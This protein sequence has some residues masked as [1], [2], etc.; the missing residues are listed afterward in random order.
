MVTC[1]ETGKTLVKGRDDVIKHI[2]A[3]WGVHPK[4][5]YKLNNPEAQKRIQ[6]LLDEA[7]KEG[8]V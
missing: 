7:K 8:M 4:D 3:V 1:P 2:I 6:R 5:A